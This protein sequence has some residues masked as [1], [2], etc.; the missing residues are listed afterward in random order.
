[1]LPSSSPAP[2]PSQLGADW[3]QFQLIQPN[4]PSTHPSGQRFLRF[5]KKRISCPKLRQS[6]F[7]HQSHIKWKDC[8][9][10]PIGHC[11]RSSLRGINLLYFHDCLKSIKYIVITLTLFFSVVVTHVFLKSGQILKPCTH[12]KKTVPKGT[13]KAVPERV[14]LTAFP[15]DM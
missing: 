12:L 7:V 11:F 10:D 8:Q 5:S 13:A 9:V 2:T 15:F 4:N 3:Y 14:H 1:M 6:I